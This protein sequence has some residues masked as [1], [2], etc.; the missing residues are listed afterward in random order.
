MPRGFEIETLSEPL[1]IEERVARMFN[2]DHTGKRL[3]ESTDS[4]RIRFDS[5]HLAVERL[6]RLLDDL[7]AA[8]SG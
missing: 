8:A 6:F 4:C 2:E 5:A 3:K 1:T 7:R